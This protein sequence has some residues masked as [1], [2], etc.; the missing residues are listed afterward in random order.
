MGVVVVGLWCGFWEK[1]YTG[2]SIFEGIF[3]DVV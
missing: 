3:Y 1:P 2:V